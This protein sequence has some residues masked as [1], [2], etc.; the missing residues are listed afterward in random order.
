MVQIDRSG[1]K[2]GSHLALMLLWPDEP[3][4]LSQWQFTAMMT[5]P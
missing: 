4:E 3:G 2:V 5:A 1:L